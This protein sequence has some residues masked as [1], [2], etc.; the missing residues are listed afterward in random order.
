M[1]TLTNAPAD[2]TS[3]HS[4]FGPGCPHCAGVARVEALRAAWVLAPRYE[5]PDAWA[6]L[7]EA[8]YP[9]SAAKPIYYCPRCGRGSS[10]GRCGCGGAR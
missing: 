6:A 1:T 8:L 4:A 2:C 7:Y 9:V 10:A 3:L 5:E